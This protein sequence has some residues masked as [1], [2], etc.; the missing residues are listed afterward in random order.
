MNKKENSKPVVIIDEDESFPSASSSLSFAE[1]SLPSKRKKLNSQQILSGFFDKIAVPE[2]FKIDKAVAR[3]LYAC[4]APFLFFA[5][6]YWKKAF[7]LL[8]PLYQIP[9]PHALSTNLLNAEYERVEIDRNQKLLESDYLTLVTD[10]LTNV[11]DGLINVIICMPRPIF[12]KTA[13][14]CKRDR[15]V[16]K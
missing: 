10:G 8:R 4:G 9:T 11:G 7:K 12:Y 13:W 1:S 14:L 6:K 2:S 16:Y 3:A 5:N 15:I